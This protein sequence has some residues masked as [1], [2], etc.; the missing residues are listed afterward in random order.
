MP[1]MLGLPDLPDSVQVALQLLLIAIAAAAAYAIL[2]AGV[3][4]AMRH[5]LERRAEET[6]P[7][8]VSRAE[9]EQRVRTIGRLIVR[10]GAAVLGIIATLMALDLFGIDIGPAVA[11]LGI[12]GIALGFG[13]QTLVRDWLSG[14]FIILENQYN[15]GDVVRIAGVEGTVEELSLRRTTLRDLDGTVH[16]VPNGQVLVASNMTRTWARV[17]LDV[18]VAYDTELER[19][20]RLIDRVGE[21]LQAD[22]GW[23]P[24]LM[25]APKVVRVDALAD[26][27]VKLKVLGRVRPG[28]QWAVTGELRKRILLAF[29][30]EGIIGGKVDAET[31]A[32]ASAA[33]E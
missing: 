4:I 28:E 20:S 8:P 24:K 31:E 23:G 33:A 21:E 30:R 2:R 22:A 6:A 15:A 16:T 7:S 5:L 32:E 25:E 11:G 10:I 17:N 13:A 26:E 29:T 19:A 27:S 1:A 9:L 14:M 3:G 12:A 18:N